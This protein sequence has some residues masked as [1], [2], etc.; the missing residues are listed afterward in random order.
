MKHRLYAILKITCAML[1]VVGSYAF[2]K[3]RYQTRTLSDVEI[4]FTDDSPPFISREEVNNLLIQNRDSI[5]MPALENLD[6]EE[7][8]K[9]L[10]ASEMVR[11]SEVSLSLDGVLRAEVEQRRPVARIIAK[12][13][14][15]L[16]SD[17]ELMPLSRQ[18]TAFV[19]LVFNYNAQ[20]QDDLFRLVMW[21]E[22]SVLAE[23]FS[24][25][26]MNGKNFYLKSPVHDA[27]VILGGIDKLEKKMSSYRAMIAM[28]E[29]QDGIAEIE[30]MDLRY[31]GQVVTK[32]IKQ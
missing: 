6:L 31:D 15:Y 9:M 1:V 25:I 23:H 30:S 16:D 12:T 13:G 32:K 17:N 11:R 14:A 4:I 3:A 26:V 29:K 20:Y 18:H 8:E 21:L 19:P 24:Q 7:K 27:K 10:N 2:A 28:L 5:E 22:N